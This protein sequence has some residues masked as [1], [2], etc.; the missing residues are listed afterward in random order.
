MFPNLVAGQYLI[1]G[2]MFAFRVL[3]NSSTTL[4]LRGERGFWFFC[5]SFLSIKKWNRG[6]PVEKMTDFWES[7]I[8]YD[9]EEGRHFRGMKGKIS[10][11]EKWVI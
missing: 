6:L 1:S 11:Q 7:Q 4:L 9:N 8:D 5:F 2:V 10:T 3:P